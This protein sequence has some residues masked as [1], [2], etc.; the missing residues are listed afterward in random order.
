MKCPKCL[1]ENR[2]AIKFCEQCGTKLE[3]VYAPGYFYLGEHYS[4]TGRPEAALEKLRMA[5]EL[6]QKMGM[7]YWLTKTRAVVGKFQT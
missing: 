4:E 7:D 5:E 1:F 6:F 2:E 3:L